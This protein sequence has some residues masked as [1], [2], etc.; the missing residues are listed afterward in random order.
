MSPH[1][2]VAAAVVAVAAVVVAEEL[3]LPRVAASMGQ[4]CGA[5]QRVRNFMQHFFNPL[6]V[7]CRLKDFGVPAPRARRISKVYE[8]YVYNYLWDAKLA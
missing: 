6:H 5:Q 2:I 7:Y 3:C 4:T 1:A 8:R